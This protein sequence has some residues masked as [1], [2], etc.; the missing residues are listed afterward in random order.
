MIGSKRSFGRGVHLPISPYPGLRP[1]NTDEWPIFFGRERMIDE[2]IDH[3]GNQQFVLIHGASGGGKSSLVRA[4]VIAQL[5]REHT[6]RNLVWSPAT[7]LPGSSPMWHFATALLTAA[8]DEG[9]DDHSEIAKARLRIQRGAEGVFDILKNVD[10]KS[11]IFIL[12]DQ[13]EEIFRLADEGGVR[14]AFDFIQLLISLYHHPVENVY[15]ALT[16]RS[17]HLGDC[18]RFSGLSEMV[19]ETQYLVPPM[20]EPELIDALCRPAAIFNGSIDSDLAHKI[21]GETTHNPDQLPLIQ[22]AASYMWR[23]A[24]PSHDGIIQLGVDEY[25]RTCQGSTK[26]AISRHADSIVSEICKAFPGN[27]KIIEKVFRALTKTDDTGRA[28]RRR[29][30]KGELL[31]EI[32]CPDFALQSILD[33]FAAAD[34]S[35][36]VSERPNPEHEAKVDISH[37]ALIR[38][39]KQLSDLSTDKNGQP[40]GWL[41]R[42]AIDGQIWRSLV[43]TIRS[44]EERDN[45]Y[46]PKALYEARRTWWSSCKPTPTWSARYGNYHRDVKELLDRSKK[47]AEEEERREKEAEIAKEKARRWARITTL[48]AC[49]AALI[50]GASAWIIYDRNSA[51]EAEK[52]KAE[53]EKHKAEGARQLA[54][55]EKQKAELHEKNAIRTFERQW[56][57]TKTAVKD[58]S[59]L[60]KMLASI[61]FLPDLD[62]EDLTIQNQPL[63]PEVEDYFRRELKRFGLQ[64]RV[65]LDQGDGQERMGEVDGVAYSPDGRIVVTGTDDGVLRF[66]DSQ[67]GSIVDQIEEFPNSID[68]VAFDPE[69]RALLLALSGDGAR[70]YDIENRTITHTLTGFNDGAWSVAWHPDR[71]HVLTGGRDNV[72]RLWSRRTGGEVRRF[73]GHTDTVWDIALSPDG[74]QVLSAS[75]DS[76]ARIWNVQ[77]GEEMLRFTE[78]VGQV[79]SA[80]WSVSGNWVATGANDGTVQIWDATTGDVR[81][82]LTMGSNTSVWMT[83]FSPD[84]SELATGSGDGSVRVW[85]VETGEL[86]REVEQIDGGVDTVAWSPDGNELVAGSNGNSAYIAS[87]NKTQI[88]SD[89][90]DL[91]DAIRYAKNSLPRCLSDEDRIKAILSPEPPGWCYEMRKPPFDGKGRLLFAT[92]Q[93]DSL[94]TSQLDSLSDSAELEKIDATFD[95]VLELDPALSREV[96]R[97]R[98]DGYLSAAGRS[99]ALGNAELSDKLKQMALDLDPSVTD[100]IKVLDSALVLVPNGMQSRN[101]KRRQ[102]TVG[103][104]YNVLGARGAEEEFEF[105]EHD[106]A[107]EIVTRDLTNGAD[108]VLAL[109]DR[110]TGTIYEQNDDDGRGGTLASRLVTFLSPGQ[111]I[112]LSIKNHGGIGGFRVELKEIDPATIDTDDD[113]ELFERLA[114]DRLSVLQSEN[115]GDFIEF[116]NWLIKSRHSKY[117]WLT[118][119]LLRAGR[120]LLNRGDEEIALKLFDIALELDPLLANRVRDQ[121]TEGFFSLAVD[122]V[123]ADFDVDSISETLDKAI[124]LNPEVAP[125]VELLLSALRLAPAGEYP[126]A[127]QQDLKIGEAYYIVGRS[128]TEGVFNVEEHAGPVT[129]HTESLTEGTDSVLDLIDLE[130]DL[131]IAGNDDGGDERLASKLSADLL[132]EQRTKLKIS[133]IGNTGGF[134]LKIETR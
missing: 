17:D 88:E 112:M 74:S 83:A 76:S 29:L 64:P 101:N 4:G 123:A 68:R 103:N 32:G 59:N 30:S 56:N 84:G 87:L 78:N 40:K 23:Q 51:L 117:D 6:K 99:I 21:I 129:I 72:V 105:S 128:Q 73:E 102:L 27:R 60:N 36:L 96:L 35:F 107:I 131:I 39:W 50:F 81:W 93:L 71:E 41:A 133:N 120:Q 116:I 53:E 69:G 43:E 65:F 24:K 34:R 67:T 70:I 49:C 97:Q 57:L 33:A 91:Q 63:L 106:G 77:S 89:E 85:S 126:M 48:T 26:I 61:E 20:D 80:S 38:N 132:P 115:A 104:T 58:G 5:Q 45:V 28:I 100:R 8:R 11:R 22:H 16:M 13:F 95:R 94:A 118:D 114:R 12:V 52:Q 122:K 90:L 47:R 79:Y 9:K 127:S 31:D 37:E 42:E 111:P 110:Q 109:V 121:K 92:S 14:E 119:Y 125:R 130:S 10:K 98:V 2:V 15:L 3:I 44:T 108:S 124:A 82:H 1:F 54:E 134:I 19:N 46:L 62:S 25:V 113:E 55:E 86:L 18:V 66:W 7:M 75:S